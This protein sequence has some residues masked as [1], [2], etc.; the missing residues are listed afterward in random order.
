M[1]GMEGPYFL[2]YTI[3]LANKYRNTFAATFV[4]SVAK[5]IKGNNKKIK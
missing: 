4:P 3:V 2:A 1:N 5:S